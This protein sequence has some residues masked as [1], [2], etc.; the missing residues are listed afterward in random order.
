M[1]LSARQREHFR[2]QGYVLVE[3][4]L[5]DADLDPVIEAY[6]AF[7]DGRA[8]E[9]HR[10]GRLSQL[11]AAEPFE[12]RLA[13][14][15]TENFEIYRDIDL[16]HCRLEAVFRFLGND[17]LLDLIE[18]IIGPEI[19][20]SPI[21]HARAKLPDNL[22]GRLRAEGEESR[23]QLEAMIA[24]N[25]APWHQDAQVHLEEADPVPILTVWLPLG[26]ATPENGCLQI[27][28]RVHQTGTVYWSEGFGI[29]EANLPAGEVLTLPMQKGSVLL[30]HKLI[31][32]CSTPN[33]SDG[34]RWSMDLRYQ[35][36]GTP[37]GRSFY[38]DFAVRSRAHPG[39]VLAD[40]GEWCRQ[41]IAALEKVPTDKRPG[42][43]DRPQRPMSMTVGD[44]FN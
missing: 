20:C 18:G 37:T 38:P 4:A 17:N 34:I 32:H 15:C 27:I 8:R 35:K 26:E 21:Q 42:R 1:R 7:I 14:L 23:R 12:R 16:M 43:R 28:P 10:E 36:R 3:G 30:M 33:L 25:V 19:T 29:S 2:E 5:S 31:P 44:F 13:C 9:L 39:S 41:W 11:H 40:Y 22:K 24:E 6:E